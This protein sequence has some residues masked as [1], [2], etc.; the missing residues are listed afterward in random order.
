M[1]FGLWFLWQ[2]YR[3]LSR[4]FRK[5]DNNK[6]N[7]KDIMGAEDYFTVVN[8]TKF[9]NEIAVV[10]YIRGNK[11]SGGCKVETP[12]IAE[13]SLKYSNT[14]FYTLDVDSDA[15]HMA[16]VKTFGITKVPHFQ[17]YKDGKVVENVEGVGSYKVVHKWMMKYGQVVKEITQDQVVDH[18]KIEAIKP[19]KGQAARLKKVV[20]EKSVEELSEPDIDSEEDQEPEDKTK[21]EKKGQ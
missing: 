14:L 17:L 10:Y 16:I 20:E 13:L 19:N 9:S 15:E 8:N 3:L 7:L 12:K 5:P 1:F 6:G 18:E 2:V 11:F 4:W 21:E